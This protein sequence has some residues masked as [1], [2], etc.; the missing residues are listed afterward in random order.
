MTVTRT[1]IDQAPKTPM[2]NDRGVNHI[3]V[4]GLMGLQNVSIQVQEF[5]VGGP[6]GNYHYHESSDN[7]YMVLTGTVAAVVGGEEITLSEGEL[8]FIPAGVPHMT[9][10]GGDTM[11]RALEI[12]APPPGD[13]SHSAALPDA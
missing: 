12:Y 13:D 10:N 11:C 5:T 3:L 4:D 2:K 9:K 8:M 6:F 7:V 1:S